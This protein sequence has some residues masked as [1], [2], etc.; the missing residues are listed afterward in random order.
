M[1][2]DDFGRTAASPDRPYMQP[3]VT[4]D[5]KTWAALCH[6]SGF[7]GYFVV[8][9]FASIIGPL[10]VWLIKKD[11]STFVDE[12]GKEAIN[13]QI[14][15]SIVYAITWFLF[16][17]IIFTLVAMA[18][19]PVLGLWIVVLVIVAAIKASNGEHFRYPLTIRFIK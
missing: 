15:M 10:V 17:T 1:A 12:H 5:G 3:E 4:S 11:S 9:P 8:V 6:L 14:T 18:L 2:G 13:F 19:F 16:F 7:L